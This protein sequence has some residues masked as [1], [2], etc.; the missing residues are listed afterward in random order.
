MQISAVI[1]SSNSPPSF[2][3]KAYHSFSDIP[4]N[5]NNL[6]QSSSEIHRNPSKS[7]TNASKST[8]SPSFSSNSSFG[9][10]AAVSI[11]LDRNDGSNSVIPINPNNLNHNNNNNSSDYPI[12]PNSILGKRNSSSSP[13][14]LNAVNP[15]N[16]INPNNPNNPNATLNFSNNFPK[17]KIVASPFGTNVSGSNI[18]V[19]SGVQPISN[20]QSGSPSPIPNLNGSP[21]K[22]AMVSPKNQSNS[23]T[24]PYYSVIHRAVLPNSKSPPQSHHV[25]G[26]MAAAMANYKEVNDNNHYAAAPIKGTKIT[27]KKGGPLQVISPL[28]GL[29]KSAAVKKTVA[30][31]KK[32]TAPHAPRKRWP[33]LK[34]NSNDT[35][36]IQNNG[37]RKETL[38][39]SAE[40]TCGLLGK[41]E[42]YVLQF[43]LKS[44][45]MDAPPSFLQKL[46]F[47]LDFEENLDLKRRLGKHN[48]PGVLLE[49][50]QMGFEYKV[51]C[52]DANF[53]KKATDTSQ[54][55]LVRPKSSSI[56]TLKKLFGGISEGI[57]CM[58]VPP[59]FQSSDMG[60][61]LIK[62]FPLHSIISFSE[63]Q[64][65]GWSWIIWIKSKEQL[66]SS[67]RSPFTLMVN[68]K[69]LDFFWTSLKDLNNYL[70]YEIHSNPSSNP[71]PTSSISPETYLLNMAQ[72]KPS[73][74][75]PQ[76]KE[77]VE[78]RDKMLKN[79]KR[80]K[81]IIEGMNKQEDESISE[82][83]SLLEEQDSLT[84]SLF[85]SSNVQSMEEASNDRSDP[86]RKLSSVSSGN[87][88]KRNKI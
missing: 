50:S 20:Q 59:N 23:P 9:V 75:S 44:M 67:K 55:I 19:R 51:E 16:L 2:T 28:K 78:S 49:R 86:K 6:I 26:G 21:V 72:R 63:T 33:S 38:A 8:S 7:I 4:P 15:N 5:P 22:N 64:Q 85:T 84:L 79:L 18:V 73:N 71:F 3:K 83:K 48:L 88:S 31:P 32:A 56:D 37:Q 11:P 62:D 74:T 34:N 53:L 30:A 65:L 24:S 77:N 17:G 14:H 25:H 61:E 68:Q 13:S 41:P 47:S 69:H 80:M 60:K 66:D 35:L 45:L 70:F 36:S 54:V 82:L 46:K 1:H 12:N 76:P 40:Q 10:V 39:S 27:P 87:E 29:P 58:F 57:I 43:V 42:V 52:N 81:E